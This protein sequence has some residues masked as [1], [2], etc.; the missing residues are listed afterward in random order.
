MNGTVKRTLGVH[1]HTLAEILFEL[2][3]FFIYASGMYFL[4]S[5]LNRNKPVILMYHSVNHRDCPYV[6][7]DNVITTENFESQVKYLSRKKNV[8]SL[9]ELLEHIENSTE[10]P[11]N[12]VVLTFDDGYSDFYTN[13]Y[14]I[15]RKYGSPC[16]IFLATKFLSSGEGKWEDRLAYLIHMIDSES[17][18]I[19]VGGKNIRF[20]ASSK[21][22][23][24]NS[25]KELSSILSKTNDDDMCRIMKEIERT[26]GNIRVSN[27]TMLKWS[28]VLLFKDS[29]LVSIGAHT[30]NHIDLGKA[31]R[32]LAKSEI[33]RSKTEI[34]KIIKRR[35]CFFSYPLGKSKNFNSQTK[36]IL[37]TEGIIAAVTTIPGNV[38]LG[39][40]PLELRRIA[41]IND[42]SYR[43][44]CSLTGFS[45]QGS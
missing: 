5:Y 1:T 16:I 37:K 3:C 38:H 23:K 40:D 11:P 4:I 30:H 8:I 25:I 7:P 41:A 19:N 31:S 44:K 12:A 35:C 39:S 18:K 34:E 17:F 43:F 15:L 10:F 13:A 9:L 33:N 2:A 27:Q 36:I 29:P 28:D 20:K 24:R 6:Y 26:A 42:A 22:E 32:E 21:I 45:L 14:P